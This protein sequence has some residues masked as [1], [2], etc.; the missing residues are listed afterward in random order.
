M[1]LLLDTHTLLWLMEGNPKLSRTAAS[2]IADP[3]NRV[4]LSMA[5]IWELAIKLGLKKIGLS[6]QLD[7][8]LATAIHGYA[9]N[10][11]DISLEDCIHY[12]PLPFPLS[13]HRDPFDRMIIVHAQQHSLSIVGN[14]VAFDPYGITRLW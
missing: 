13:D 3:A 2:L 12:E 1:N 11:I 9:L 14:D 7:V 10:V 5:S 8:F 4:H 6:V